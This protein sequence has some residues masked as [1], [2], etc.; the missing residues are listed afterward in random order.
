M[1]VEIDSPPTVDDVFL[2]EAKE[3]KKTTLFPL[4][5]PLELATNSE[6][7]MAAARDTWGGFR[8]LFPGVPVSL[9]LTVTEHE[10]DRLP[11]RPKFRSQGHLLSIVCDSRNQVICDLSR[12]CAFGWVT[13]RVAE[14][15]DFLRLR[16][17]ESSVMT[18]LVNSHLAPIHGALVAR[19]GTGFLLC[20][21][22][23]AGKS[24]L[25]Y[26]CARSGWTLI[27]DDGTFLLRNQ[28]GREAIGNPTSVRFREDGRFLFPELERFRVAR[29]PNGEL[30]LEVPTSELPIATAHS[31]S[32]DHV[33]F[34]RRSAAGRARVESYKK[35]NA[36]EW[37]ERAA[38]YGPKECQ[39]SQREAYRRLADAGMW[40]LHYS[41]LDEAVRLLDRMG[42]AA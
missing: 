20:G 3:L 40:E 15:Q 9:T 33:I 42:A 4:G 39:D 23:F 19:R 5:F 22:S 7:V 12:G 38:R 34:L 17:L 27:C 18:I 28:S 11:S 6:A 10:E 41:D 24:T 37:F 35:S 32:I 13:R 26:A 16:I 1:T 31:C 21:E 30:G 14:Q 29:R 2:K 25:S 36:L 8:P